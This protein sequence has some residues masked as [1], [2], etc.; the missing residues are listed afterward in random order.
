[1]WDHM[2]GLLHSACAQELAAIV[3]VNNHWGPRC[4][5]RGM[6]AIVKLMEGDETGNPRACQRLQN[7][8]VLIDEEE[9]RLVEL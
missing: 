7:R 9:K 5:V 8:E 1:M 4:E 2:D 6:N 3:V